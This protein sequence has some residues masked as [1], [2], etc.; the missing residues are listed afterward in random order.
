MS[1]RSSIQRWKARG[2]PPS[3]E[4]YR[5]SDCEASQSTML[6]AK[7]APACRLIGPHFV[8]SEGP[9]ERVFSFTSNDW[10]RLLKNSASPDA[11][12]YSLEFRDVGWLLMTGPKPSPAPV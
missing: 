2:R 5:V 9:S 6:R 7:P 4:R 8:E 12:W 1:F 10:C 3:L 11:D